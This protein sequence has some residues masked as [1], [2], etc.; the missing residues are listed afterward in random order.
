MFLSVFLVFLLNLGSLPNSNL[1]KN[2]DEI[3]IL[4]NSL[5][6]ENSLLKEG[7]LD[8]FSYL[9][10]YK[11]KIND[12]ELQNLKNWKKE[13]QEPINKINTTI[14]LKANNLS[15]D[16]KVTLLK[17]A[18]RV[19]TYAYSPYSKFQVGAAVLLKNGKIHSGCNYENAAFGNTIC[20]ERSAIAK[21][22]SE[23]NRGNSIVENQEIIAVAIVLRTKNGSPC[24][25]CRQSLYEFNPNMLVIMSDIDLENY[26]EKYL[27]ELLP[28]GFGPVCLDESIVK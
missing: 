14:E 7:F 3:T 6:Y 5:N 11:K 10:N 16:I 13:N 21:A 27:Y 15:K 18:A 24:G 20:A 2:E 26:Q 4:Q 22:I 1:E 17:E 8:D 12:V 9:N 19:R 25:N 28:I 23:N